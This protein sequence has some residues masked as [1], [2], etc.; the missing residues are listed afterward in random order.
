MAYINDA[1]LQVLD[2]LSVILCWAELSLIVS[3][4]S[5]SK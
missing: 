2:T 5:S 4:T 3:Q 1:D